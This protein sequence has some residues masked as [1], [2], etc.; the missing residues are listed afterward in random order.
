MWEQPVP[1]PVHVFG[2]VCVCVWERSRSHFNMSAEPMPQRNEEERLWSVRLWQTGQIYGDG[3]LTPPYFHFHQHHST[4]QTLIT[5]QTI[6]HASPSTQS[7]FLQVL[8][9]KEGIG[10]VSEECACA[11]DIYQPLKPSIM[12]L[13]QCWNLEN[14][15]FVYFRVMLPKKMTHLEYVH[16]K[17]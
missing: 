15:F 6:K 13:Q 17:N 9:R 5:R 1:V 7:P 4:I 2:S 12:W 8:K 11:D 16:L 3:L 14:F 10:T